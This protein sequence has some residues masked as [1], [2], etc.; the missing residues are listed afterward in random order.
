MAKQDKNRT[1][2]VYS[3]NP[4]FEY[5][6]NEEVE[7]DTLAPSKQ[8]LR[9]ALDTK[10]RAGK[11]VTLISGFIGKSQDLEN[12]GKKLKT[13]CSVGGTV[14]D[15]LIVLQGDFREKALKVLLDEGYKAKR[16]N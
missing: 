9:V 12:L 8:D 14:K 1:G 6:S 3:T 16:A 4:D 11:Q 13:K 15:G 5:Q 10:M 7:Q 2:V